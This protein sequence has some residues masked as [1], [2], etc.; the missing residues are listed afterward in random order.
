MAGSRSSLTADK[1]VVFNCSLSL[2]LELIQIQI[3]TIAQIPELQSEWKTDLDLSAVREPKSN[4]SYSTSQDLAGAA[5]Y[6]WLT[7]ADHIPELSGTPSLLRRSSVVA[8]GI[9]T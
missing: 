7:I 4:Y 9:L 6:S 2:R 5:L 8:M 3:L 1:S